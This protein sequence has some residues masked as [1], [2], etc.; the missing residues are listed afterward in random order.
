MMRCNSRQVN[1]LERCTFLSALYTSVLA[2]SLN[3]T[4]RSSMDII[5]LRHNRRKLRSNNRSASACTVQS[6]DP[7]HSKVLVKFSMDFKCSQT[8]AMR[9]LCDASPDAEAPLLHA[10]ALQL[11]RYATVG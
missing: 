4:V 6:D 10:L 5:H 3:C 8:S 9:L 2:A 11:T 1:L 7:I